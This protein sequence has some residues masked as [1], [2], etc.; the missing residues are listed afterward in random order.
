MTDEPV[1]LGSTPVG[2]GKIGYTADKHT[3][4]RLKDNTDLNPEETEV[5][6]EFT[7]QNGYTAYM[8]GDNVYVTNGVSYWKFEMGEGPEKLGGI[9]DE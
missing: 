4:E 9:N 3:I 2:N 6:R 5:I 7:G 1:I 8:T